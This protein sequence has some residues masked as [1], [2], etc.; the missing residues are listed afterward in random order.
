MENKEQ[1]K[2]SEQKSGE[3]AKRKKP[4]RLPFDN[5]K[6]DFVSWIY[7]HRIG[8]CV[9]II[10]YLSMSITFVSSKIAMGGHPKSSTIVID[11]QN[12]ALLEEERDRLLEE[13]KRKNSQIDW[14]SIKN[15]SS[16]ENAL[17]EN[18]ADAKG[19]DV[20]ELN[21]SALEA[22]RHMEENRRAYEKGLRAA[23]KAGERQL[24]DDGNDQNSKSGDSKYKGSVTVSFNIANPTRYSRYL[25]KPS[26]RCEAGGEVVIGVTVDQ[27]GNVV[28]A[29]VISG[30]DECM[31][32]TALESARKSKFDI[33]YDAPQRQS[34]TITYIFI[35]Q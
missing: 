13:I 17:N 1:D 30:G 5:R 29:Q 16:N 25:D 27:G 10:I 23:A 19:T 26:Y 14:N 20:T 34:G 12:A 33:N 21:E 22:Q 6:T 18:L 11:M 32:R 7:D 35:P 3:S 15:R 9:V 2:L 4:L 31:R 24:A 28:V 8:L